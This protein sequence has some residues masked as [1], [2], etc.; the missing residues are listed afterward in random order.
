M[1]NCQTPLQLANPTQLQLDGEGVD[2][3]QDMPSQDRSSQLRSSQ[4]MKGLDRA[5]HAR[6]SLVR[7]SQDM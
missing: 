7:L 5:S 2:F 4:E 3:G 6:P 1:H